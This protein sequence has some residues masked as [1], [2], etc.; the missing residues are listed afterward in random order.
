MH[1]FFRRLHRDCK[2]QARLADSTRI[3]GA[4]CDV[5]CGATLTNS[6][7]DLLTCT[8]YFVCLGR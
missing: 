6:P 2:G 1:D 5:Q 3:P 7:I 4:T 8:F